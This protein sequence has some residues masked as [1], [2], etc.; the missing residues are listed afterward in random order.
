M[1]S[2]NPY[3][4]DSA[5]KDLIEDIIASPKG[6]NKNKFIPIGVLQNIVDKTF[7]EA[8]G[9]TPLTQRLQDILGEALELSR[10]T[11]LKN[12]REE[13]G[14][15][16]AS[17]LQLINE[18]GWDV[19]DLIQENREKIVSRELQYKSLGRKKKVALLGGA[20]DPVHKGHIE[21]AQFV[22]NTSKTFDEV[23][24]MPC[25]EH[26]YNKN[27]QSAEHRLNMC[28]IATRNDGRL[29]VFDFEI[30]QRLSGETYN[31]VKRLQ[32]TDMAKNEYDF[33]LIMGLD[34]AN[35]FSQW[36]NYE[37]LERMI[38]FVVVQRVGYEI[39]PK[40]DWYLKSPHIFLGNAAINNMSSTRIR[41]VLKDREKRIEDMLRH[42]TAEQAN[43]KMAEAIQK[44]IGYGID[45]KVLNYIY[46]NNLYAN[47]E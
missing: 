41:G 29:K 5:A 13:T 25:Y 42:I 12:L 28:K 26:M 39:D 37:E 20:F 23:W 22:L 30:E 2:K 32:D 27:M 33:S 11:D 7:T 18:C 40:V 44:A 15:L 24:L 3:D 6:D 45:P 16:L 47:R 4:F 31:M 46:E 43:E 36:V 21:L 17:T 8:F 10:Y 19:A 9:T 34:N 14:D 1:N 35:T 38:R